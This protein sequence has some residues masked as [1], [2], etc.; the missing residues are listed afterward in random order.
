[1]EQNTQLSD[2][3]VEIKLDGEGEPISPKFKKKNNK[4]II[5]LIILILII[6]SAGTVYF[7][8]LNKND[9]G[10]L[11]SKE[12][13]EVIENKEVAEVD[14]IIDSDQDELPDYLEKILGT[15]ENNS[16]TDGDG[17]NDFEE[18]RNGYN[19]LNEKKFKEGE[20]GEIKEI[21]KNEDEKLFGE[22]VGVNIVDSDFICGTDTVND[23]DGNT[24]NTVQIGEQC[25]LKENLKVTKNPAGEAIT[26]YCY[27]NDPSI[28]ETD[29]GLYDWNTTMNNST[30]EGAQGICPDGWHVFTDAQWQ[31]L[32][33]KVVNV[34]DLKVG[35]SIGFEGILSGIRNINGSFNGR[36]TASI[37]WTST[38][39]EGSVWSR[40]LGDNI[41]KIIRLT[42]D[43]KS[44]FSVRCLKD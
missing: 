26:R 14:K 33:N 30:T 40:P 8:F 22:I 10:K 21:I 15:D 24:Y 5:L 28:C 4:K 29:G 7:L 23:I 16:D 9:D 44:G 25:W 37:F 19:P 11:P 43:K 18:I 1:M 38:V 2:N 42:N 36:Y 20:W 41:S 34:I 31:D 17:Y 12:N 6:I 32:L 39:E 27:D 35:N 3:P 13:V